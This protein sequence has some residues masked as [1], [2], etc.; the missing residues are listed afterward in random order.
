MADA[1]YLT[2]ES[3]F[4]QLPSKEQLRPALPLGYNYDLAAPEA[5]MRRASVKDGHLVFPDGMSYQLLVLPPG[6]TMTV[7][8]LS[9]LKELVT[10]GATLVGPPPTNSPSLAGF[11]ECDAQV[12]QLAG[13]L[14]GGCDGKNVTRR[15]C[16]KGQIIWGESL[17]QVF[18]SKGLA[19]DFL[20]LT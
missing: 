1:C 18:A 8:L 9:K 13:E 2:T 20:V 17:D 4:A 10:A 11:P 6:R 19:P 7:P 14:W 15:A 5:I 12:K 16:G 3:A